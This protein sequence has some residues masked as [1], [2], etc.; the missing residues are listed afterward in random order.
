V[1]FKSAKAYR[2]QLHSGKFGYWIL[3]VATKIFGRKVNYF[4]C[5]AAKSLHST[6]L[7]TRRVAVYL[8][9]HCN[10][11]SKRAI[12]TGIL[13]RW[14][15]C[16]LIHG[17]N[18]AQLPCP[19][20]FV[21][22]CVTTQQDVH[23]YR[24][25]L[26]KNVGSTYLDA[27]YSP[28]ERLWI[29]SNGKKTRG[30]I[31]PRVFGICN[32]CGVMTA[33]SRKTWTFKAIFAYFLES[34]PL[35]NCRYCTDHA[36]NLPGPAPHIWLTLFQ[37]SSK[38]VHLRRIYCWTR[39]DRFCPVDYLQ[40]RLLEPIKMVLQIQVATVW[41]IETTDYLRSYSHQTCTN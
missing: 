10:I 27:E 14:H 24:Q 5:S 40:Y 15:N 25:R 38:S 34:R 31:W 6:T 2:H 7:T 37:I 12:H 20:R 23:G 18:T 17:C 26:P 19:H 22:F 9:T 32:H 28:G 3:T 1:N 39:E 16:L 29:D 35:S 41:S 36:H 11:G 30:T 8:E 33:W 4:I 13:D 21:Y